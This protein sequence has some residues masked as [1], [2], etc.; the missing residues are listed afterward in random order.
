MLMAA[1]IRKTLMPRVFSTR[2]RSIVDFSV[3]LKNTAPPGGTGEGRWKLRAS[4]HETAADQEDSFSASSAAAGSDSTKQVLNLK[5]QKPFARKNFC[6][7]LA[8]LHNKSRKLCNSVNTA[9]SHETQS[10]M[11][12]RRDMT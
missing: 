11:R 10:A 8:R 5:R 4:R 12:R 7:N 1:A 9:A 2:F 3:I 6:L